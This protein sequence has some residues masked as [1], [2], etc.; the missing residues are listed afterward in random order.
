MLAGT[1][2]QC[3]LAAWRLSA[4][5]AVCLTITSDLT[6]PGAECLTCFNETANAPLYARCRYLSTPSVVPSLL[7]VGALHLPGASGPAA[8][9]LPWLL[10]P[11]AR[12]CDEAG[13]AGG[14]AAFAEEQRLAGVGSEGRQAAQAFPPELM[15]FVV[16]RPSIL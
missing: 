7:A 11:S 1:S 15:H 10:L 3:G 2:S 14:G 12:N 8:S 4:V 9:G 16:A 6:M 13:S 5:R